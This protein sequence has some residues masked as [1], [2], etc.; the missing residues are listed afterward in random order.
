M[1]DG[2]VGVVELFFGVAPFAVDDHWTISQLIYSQK[3]FPTYL[4]SNIYS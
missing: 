4:Y 1:T 2:A 3:L